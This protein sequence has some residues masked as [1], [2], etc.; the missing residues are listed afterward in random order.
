MDCCPSPAGFVCHQT[1]PCNIEKDSSG[2]NKFPGIVQSEGQGKK[3]NRGRFKGKCHEGCS[4]F[5]SLK[6]SL[7][8]NFFYLVHTFHFLTRTNHLRY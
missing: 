5:L 3:S 7:F 1:M 6:Y 8:L 4:C 2:S